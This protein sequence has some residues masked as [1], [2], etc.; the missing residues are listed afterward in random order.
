MLNGPLCR[1]DHLLRSLTPR[2]QIRRPV[3]TG[4]VAPGTVASR[5]APRVCTFPRLAHSQGLLIM[6][7]MCRYSAERGA[8]S[9]IAPATSAVPIRHR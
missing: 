9:S 4:A 8:L 1:R 5:P 2:S 7:T 6:A 3:A